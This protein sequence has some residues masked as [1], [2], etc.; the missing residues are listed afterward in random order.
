MQKSERM[1]PSDIQRTYKRDLH[2]MDRL[3]KAFD[4]HCSKTAKSSKFN[5][6]NYFPITIALQNDLKLTGLNHD[7]SLTHIFGAC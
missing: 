2:Y 1:S 6:F 5:I 4:V 7:H 3:I